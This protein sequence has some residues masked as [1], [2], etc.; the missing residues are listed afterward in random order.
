MGS[1]DNL[2]G[3]TLTHFG[4]H[5]EQRLWSLVSAVFPAYEIFWRRYVVPLTNRVDR[6]VP[7][8]QDRDPWIRVRPDV[9]ER[10]EQLA[11]HHYSVFYYLARAAEHANSN[12]SEFPEDVFSL[13]DACGDNALAFCILARKILTDFGLSIDFLPSRK[14]QLCCSTDRQKL[15]T[16][17]G[18]LV[19]VREYRD[20]ILH[21]PVLGRG[22]QTPRQFLP[23]REFLEEVKLSWMKA[24]RLTAEQM[25]ESKPLYARLLS[26]TASFLQ[27]TWE[28]LIQK[29]DT[30]REGDKF[31]KQWSIHEHFLPIAPAPVLSRIGRVTADSSAV[32]FASPSCSGAFSVP[33]I[34]LEELER[35]NKD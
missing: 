24:A 5:H 30:V 3:F 1:F 35:L 33:A 26:E 16:H 19:E 27:E 34:T 17:R 18:G 22:I 25:V 20:T 11:M 13:L 23:K 31:R 32:T 9:H 6:N 14:D 28:V 7:F 10:Q 2:D 21:N 8:P 29:L 4:D 12:E 15:S